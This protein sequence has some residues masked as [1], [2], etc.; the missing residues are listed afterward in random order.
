MFIRSWRYVIPL[1]LRSL[2]RRRRLEQ[3]LD[4]EFQFHLEQHIQSAVA[5]GLTPAAARAQA[6]EALDNIPLR[7]EE[8]RDMRGVNFIHD[9]MQDV[10]YAVRTLRNSPAFSLIAILSLAL[11]IGANTAIFSVM[12]VLLLRPLP[13]HDPASL[14]LVE[15]TGMDAKPRTSFNYPMF[16][17]I[18]DR[19]S[20]S[21][22]PSPGPPRNC[23]RQSATT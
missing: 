2:L 4:E 22:P 21:P 3:E 19:T 1:R 9:L 8:C 13:V 15:L 23:R 5:H 14:Q 7:K 18:R 10:R 6:I 17:L 20:R 12:D 16:E 11:G